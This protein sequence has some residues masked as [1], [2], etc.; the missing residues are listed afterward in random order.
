M[1]RDRILYAPAVCCVAAFILATTLATVATA[2]IIPIEP[3]EDQTPQIAPPPSVMPVDPTTRGRAQEG[4]DETSERPQR[5]S[6]VPLRVA[7]PRIDGSP[8]HRLGGDVDAARFI[9]FLPT[10]P[11]AA[12]LHI[13]HR[14]GI[15]ALPERSELSVAVNGT[16]I[17]SLRPDNFDTFGRDTLAVAN[18]ILQSGRNE[19]TIKARHTHRVACGPDASF[20][21]WTEIDTRVSGVPLSADSFALD[22]TGFLAAIAA[23]TAQGMPITIRRE[24]PAASLSDAAPLISDV[25]AA[26]GGAPP[27]LLSAPYWGLATDKPELARVTA[28]PPGEGAVAPRFVRGGD[29]ALVLLLGRT[30]DLGAVS[31]RLVEAAGP[32]RDQHLRPTTPGTAQPLSALGAD[33][34]VGEGRYIHL[35]VDFR[36]P[37]DWVVLASQKAR[38]DLDYRFAAGLPDGALLLV[39]VNGTTV[40]LLPLS[41]N[42]GQIQPTLPIS[43]AAR[44]LNPGVNRLEF[45]ALVPGDPPNAACAPLDGPVVEISEGSQLLVPPSPRMTLASLDK[46]LA[47]L[48]SADIVRGAGAGSA[49]QPGVLPQIAAALAAPN[50]KTAVDGE[51]STQLTVGGLSDLAMI[52]APLVRDNLRALEAT[53][54][55]VAPFS[56]TDQP[57]AEPWDEAKE[58]DRWF[59]LPDASGITALPGRLAR[60]VSRLA[61]G[62]TPD[63]GDWLQGRNG[64]A[65]LLQPD[66]TRPSDLWLV[67]GL[68]AEPNQIAR[69]LAASHDSQNG[70]TGQVALYSEGTGWTSWTAPDRPLRL[71]EPLSWATIRH[72]MGNHATLAPVTFVAAIVMLTL[73]SAL[74]S[75]AILLLTRRRDP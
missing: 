34:L 21:L 38:L 11:G 44:L 9:L 37:W 48:T 41:Q 63:L 52:E 58:R 28:L 64:Q 30:E 23:Q 8:L 72:V 73:A 43:F 75:M 66:P 36:M 25:A 33:R 60:A 14:S 69:V 65:M 3:R 68:D 5:L 29:G 49:W 53:L 35:S 1:I 56:T 26:L 24:D 7:E 57:T 22:P 32:L 70:P 74:V 2:Q 4:V 17:G 62:D 50:P 19:V 55:G 10:A 39:K 16:V 12:D 61:F 40:R 67:L 46:S 6:L 15:D 27:A 45:E 13:S 71:H 51:P 59:G 20:A 54:D 18:G 31:S 47:A 42:G